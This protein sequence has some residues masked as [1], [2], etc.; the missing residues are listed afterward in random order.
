M[1]VAWDG[2]TSVPHGA[3]APEHGWRP[4]AGS[5]RPGMPRT[6]ATD[7]G[8]LADIY[9]TLLALV[10]AA[11]GLILLGGWTVRRRTATQAKK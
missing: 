1:G 5:G 2:T 11:G 9:A 10:A 6:G 3:Y 8:H 7:S 4:A